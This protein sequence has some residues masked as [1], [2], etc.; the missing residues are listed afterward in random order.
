MLNEGDLL[1]TRLS[2]DKGSQQIAV[3]ESAFSLYNYIIN[4][5]FNNKNSG[6]HST[7][8]IDNIDHK[9]RLIQIQHEI[10]FRQDRLEGVHDRLEI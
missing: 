10:A 5:D 7:T 2:G 1:L 6:A 3:A 4:R 8:D 9:Q